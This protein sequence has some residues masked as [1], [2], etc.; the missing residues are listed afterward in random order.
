[1]FRRCTSVSKEV[2]GVLEHPEGSLAFPHFGLHQP[3]KSGGWVQTRGREWVCSVDQGHYGHL[4]RKATWLLYVGDVEPPELEWGPA[5]VN[6]PKRG[7]IEM[8]SKKQRAATPI[9]FRN[10]LIAMARTAVAK[11]RTA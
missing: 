1:M 4:A 3:P 11:R 9:P 6:A 2:G 7:N 5:R 10:L 8:M